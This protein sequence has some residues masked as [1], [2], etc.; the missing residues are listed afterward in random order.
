MKESRY[1]LYI[2]NCAP[3]HPS[4][5]EVKPR[6]HLAEYF[7]RFFTIEIDSAIAN[8]L[9]PIGMMEMQ[10]VTINPNICECVYDYMKIHHDRF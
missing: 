9:K 8:N 7:F 3:L 2:L 1:V 10:C 6:S 5:A 4:V